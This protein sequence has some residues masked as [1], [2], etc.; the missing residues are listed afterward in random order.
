M[1]GEKIVHE[2]L[3]K[4]HY[5]PFH[6]QIMKAGLYILFAML[7]FF[8]GCSNLQPEAT[9]KIAK[10]PGRYALVKDWPQLPEGYT[11]GNP[12][13]IGMDTSQN[14][15]VFH[16]A[17]RTWPIIMPMPRS[18]IKSNTILLLNGQSGRVMNSWGAN[19]FIMP[20]GLTVDAHNN[21]WVTDVGAH[22]VFK[23]SHEG[24]LMMKLGEAKVAGNN[25]THFNR[26]TD[27]AVA[28]DG[29]FYVSDGYENSR[30]IK[31][32]AS[33]SYLLE[34]GRNGHK[35]G[36]FNIPHGIDLDEAGN[37]YVADRENSR[38][39]VFDSSGNFLRQYAADTFGK[40]YAVAFD[41]KQKQ[42]IATDYIQGFSTARGSDI[43]IFDS[44]QNATIKFGRS[45]S[46]K[47]PV[48]R[49]HD[50]VADAAGSLY[51]GDI[52]GN[53]I[54]KFKRTAQ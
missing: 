54:Q 2:L 22:Q 12:T 21:V 33:G 24:V 7:L 11:L 9:N 36:E 35:Q 28:P 32:S 48:C 6:N 25:R 26:P 14:I 52:L 43:I 41:K 23:F 53:R 8:G 29:S 27:V 45:G 37:V 30:I 4:F 46:Y 17:G 16:R 5:H 15:F 34:W 10:T 40:L 47:G 39:Q 1:N 38:I 31:F 42:L 44:I 18:Y 50:V 20:H 19:Q 51:V 3:K 49:Y 13:G